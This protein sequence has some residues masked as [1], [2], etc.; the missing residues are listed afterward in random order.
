LK[1]EN[2]NNVESLKLEKTKY[3]PSLE[4]KKWNDPDDPDN[5]FT[6][7]QRLLIKRAKIDV[8]IVLRE[9]DQI[10]KYELFQRLNTGG[11]SLTPQEV[12]NCIMV[13]V[14]PDFHK[15]LRVLSSHQPYQEC[16]ALSDKNISEQYDIELALRF[17]VFS[18]LDLEKYDRSKD[19]GEYLTDRMVEMA[20]D[21]LFDRKSAETRFRET[22]DHLNDAL[23]SNA[24]RRYSDGQFKG[25][26]LLSPFEVVSFGLGF[27]HPKFPPREV[28]AERTQRLYSD[29]EYQ[30]WS[31]SGVRANSRL[32][33]LIPLG[34][35]IFRP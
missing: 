26:F 3:L 29:E 18:T 17:I 33:H 9:S 22:F 20:Q 28:T 1:D 12:R 13:M 27:N 15:W 8:S 31:G 19:V 35:E 4:G 16:I 32:P 7:E 30:Q 25:G 10:A 5:S 6:P 2:G 14:K 24:F 21:N 11:A 34:R 23:G